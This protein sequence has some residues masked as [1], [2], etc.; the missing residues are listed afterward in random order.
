MKLPMRFK[1]QPSKPAHLFVP[2]ARNVPAG[3]ADSVVMLPKASGTIRLVLVSTA[4][5]GSEAFCMHGFKSTC[6]VLISIREQADW[7]VGIVI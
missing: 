6:S 1:H 5:P 3:Q 7:S 2:A 4:G